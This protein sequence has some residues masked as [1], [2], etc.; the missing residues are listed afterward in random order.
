M[1]RRR[2]G[3]LTGVSALVL[4]VAVVMWVRSLV[5]EDQVSVVVADIRFGVGSSSQRFWV[6]GAASLS[7]A[8]AVEG[9]FG[10]GSAGETRWEHLLPA[11]RK[12][13]W[14]RTI[15]LPYWFVVVPAAI[16]PVR[17]FMGRRGRTRRGRR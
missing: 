3:I 16:M 15:L 9:S 7:E 1:K 6:K 8:M 2:F 11:Y 14:S 17:S 4:A 12:G 10:E 5:W 13:M